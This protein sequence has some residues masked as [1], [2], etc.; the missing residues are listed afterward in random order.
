LNVVIIVER[1]APGLRAAVRRGGH[2]RGAH[3]GQ[4]N[5]VSAQLREH[6]HA[7]LLLL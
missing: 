6:R 4:E 2:E 7:G 5:P 1:L 3:N